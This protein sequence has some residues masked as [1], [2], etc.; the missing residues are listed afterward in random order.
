GEA[1]PA[2]IGI[3]CGE[4]QCRRVFVIARRVSGKRGDCDDDQCERDEAPARERAAPD[5]F[6]VSSL[7]F[8]EK[9]QRHCPSF[10]SILIFINSSKA[11]ILSEGGH[12][13]FAPARET[14]VEG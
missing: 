6:L 4:K 14:R 8:F 5:R 2:A 10:R 11:V 9:G 1:Q 13:A 3:A 7:S 12:R